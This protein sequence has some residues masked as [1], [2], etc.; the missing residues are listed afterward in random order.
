MLKSSNEI[1]NW[2]KDNFFESSSVTFSFNDMDFYDVQTFV[3]T[4]SLEGS[5]WTHNELCVKGVKSYDEDGNSF[6]IGVLILDSRVKT[7]EDFLQ[8]AA[9]FDELYI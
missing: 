2:A 3:D 7:R 8:L 1:K 5:A 6:V 4:L 9:Y